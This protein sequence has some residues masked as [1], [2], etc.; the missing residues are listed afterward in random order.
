MDRQ[1]RVEAIYQRSDSG[2]GDEDV[3]DFN[4]CVDGQEPQIHEVWTS[5]KD[6][7][8]R[9]VHLTVQVDFGAGF[10]GNVLT[11]Y[12]TPNWHRI[13]MFGVNSING[14]VQWLSAPAPL[15]TNVPPWTDNILAPS[16]AWGMVLLP[17]I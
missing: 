13:P 15:M 9:E 10:V 12:L 11:N 1:E 8:T 5:G 17:P 16:S 2:S 3:P 6:G 7:V 4:R 14:S